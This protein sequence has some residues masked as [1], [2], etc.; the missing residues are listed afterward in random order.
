MS[1][2]NALGIVTHNL[3]KMSVK[4]DQNGF[5]AVDFLFSDRLLV[6]SRQE[7]LRMRAWSRFQSRSFKVERLSCDFLPL[8]MPILSLA[9]PRIQ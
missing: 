8:A 1:V 9:R 7:G 4:M 6:E 2:A 3:T 5:S